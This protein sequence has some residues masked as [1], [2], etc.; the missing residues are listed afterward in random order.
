[1]A[2]RVDESIGG[3]E[4][5]EVRSADFLGEQELA[6][7]LLKIKID[8][9]SAHKVSDGVCVLVGLLLDN[10]NDIFKLFLVLTR[11]ARPISTGDNGGRQVAQ[12]PRTAGL[13]GINVVRG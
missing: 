6:L 8:I 3:S 11:V 9:E 4:K 5:E 1:M 13:D 7:G 12:N 10:A 2:R